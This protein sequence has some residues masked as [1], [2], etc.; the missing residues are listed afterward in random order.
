MKLFEN[1]ILYSPLRADPRV[2][3]QAHEI[4][5][6]G[7]LGGR[8]R[9]QKME[10]ALDGSALEMAV[11]L[12]LG[13]IGDGQG[14]EILDP[15]DR[16]HDIRLK[17]RGGKIFKIDVKGRFSQGSKTFTMNEWE[18]S[19]ADQE[20]LYL[21]FNADENEARY[22]GWFS[23][24]DLEEGRYGPFIWISNLRKENPFA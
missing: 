15:E 19:N 18:V 11:R 22:I 1:A 10:H 24:W 16:T 7:K 2:L 21:V 5:S 9:E 23:L 17:R 4:G 14:W 20:T 13:V 6:K 12:E 8:T 3:Q